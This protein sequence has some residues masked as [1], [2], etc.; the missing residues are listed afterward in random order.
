MPPCQFLTL[1]P[2]PVSC[3]SLVARAADDYGEAQQESF[4]GGFPGG[5]G[6]FPGSADALVNRR[7]PEGR[8]TLSPSIPSRPPC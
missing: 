2:S 7:P 3:D 1:E 5:L 4:P 6:R 8:V